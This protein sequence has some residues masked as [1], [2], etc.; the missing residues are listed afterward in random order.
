MDT[1]ENIRVSGS[2][3]DFGT[4]LIPQRGFDGSALTHLHFSRSL[5]SIVWLV[6]DRGAA[7]LVVTRRQGARLCVRGRLNPTAGLNTSIT[8]TRNSTAA[9]WAFLGGPFAE[10]VLPRALTAFIAF[11]HPVYFCPWRSEK[12]T[13]METKNRGLMGALGRAGRRGRTGLRF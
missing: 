7:F 6:R 4:F 1:N 8:K 5:Q 3:P 9:Y 2:F 12:C 11:A 10:W 13:R